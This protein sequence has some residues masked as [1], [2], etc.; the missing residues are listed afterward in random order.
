[1]LCNFA[2]PA[3][4]QS[5]VNCCV[6]PLILVMFAYKIFIQCKSLG[7]TVL[8]L[9][10]LIWNSTTSL[11]S[12]ISFPLTFFQVQ[13]VL[14][15]TYCFTIGSSLPIIFCYRNHFCTLVCHIPFVNLC[16]DFFSAEKYSIFK[17]FIIRAGKFL[18]TELKHILISHSESEIFFKLI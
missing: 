12:V 9:P 1:M 2:Q 7:Q 17:I 8:C 10:E 13:S 16:L 18:P 4:S 15:L 3:Q 6:L 14:S 5:L 11:I